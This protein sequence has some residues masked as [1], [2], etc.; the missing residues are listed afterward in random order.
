MR[1]A[2]VGSGISDLASAF[3]PWFPHRDSGADR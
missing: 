3:L 2:V 1:L